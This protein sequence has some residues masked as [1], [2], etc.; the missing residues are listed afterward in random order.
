EVKSSK[1]YQGDKDSSAWDFRIVITGA[2]NSDPRK[3]SKIIDGYLRQKEFIVIN[4]NKPRS[5][6]FSLRWDTPLDLEKEIEGLKDNKH[7]T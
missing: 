4:V 7:S 6:S 3:A 5:E 1:K 2:S